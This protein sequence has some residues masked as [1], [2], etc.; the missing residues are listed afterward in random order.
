MGNR[1]KPFPLGFLAGEYRGALPG[2]MLRS[3]GPFHHR[4]LRRL[5]EFQGTGTTDTRAVQGNSRAASGVSEWL[6]QL[7]SQGLTW[8]RTK[9]TGEV[10]AWVLLHP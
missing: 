1:G 7:W 8:D 6:P 5:K 2:T 9:Q 4:E 3:G 10:T